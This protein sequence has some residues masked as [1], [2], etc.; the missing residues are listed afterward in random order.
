MSSISAEM[1]RVALGAGIGVSVSLGVR[2]YV[3]A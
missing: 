1:I 2:G 3:W